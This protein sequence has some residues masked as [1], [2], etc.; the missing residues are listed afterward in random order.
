MTVDFDYLIVG[1]GFG[2]SVSAMRL[3]EKGYRVGVFEQGK[4][5]NAGDFP[6]SN[7]DLRKY[8]WSPLFKCF[9]IQNLSLFKNILILSGTGVGGGSLVYANTLLQP[10]DLF[11]SSTAWKDITDW[12]AELLPHFATAKQMLGVNPNPNL[13]DLDRTLQSIADEMGRGDTFKSSEVGIFFG[14]PNKTVSDPYFSGRGPDR[15]GCTFCGGCMVGC[16]HNAKNTLDKNYLYFAEKNGAEIFPET[17]VTDIRPIVGPD[18][19]TDGSHGYEIYTERSTAWLK[20]DRKIFRANRVVLSG[21]VLGTVSL[22]LKLKHET[23]SLPDISNCLGTEVRTNSEAL[24]G[25]TQRSYSAEHDFSRGPAITS[26]FHPDEHTHI[27]P[28]RY[29]RG[30][31]FMR[32]LGV[33]MTDGGNRFVRPLR[34]IWTMIRHPLDLKRLLFNRQWAETTILFLVMQTL[35]NKMRFQLGRNIFTLFRRRMTTA[36]DPL[37]PHIPSYIPIGHQVARAFAKRVNGVPISAINEVLLDI[38]TTAHILGGCAI[39]ASPE[40]GVIDLNHQVFGYQGLYVCDGSAIPANLGVNP[41]LTIT[42]MTE[43]AMSKIP[44]KPR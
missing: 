8:L 7:W 25:V 17:R 22:L 12:K 15:T 44:R 4:R 39:G 10:G 14:E 26:I 24:V 23:M 6:Q 20:K 37:S 43:R 35:D 19:K 42:A 16:K 33:P 38:P 5:F 3:T 36:H 41:S 13:T 32:I 40:K 30:S 9:G 11:F 29:P 27:E 2:G 34:M 1:S 18:G 28:C 21:G 31:D